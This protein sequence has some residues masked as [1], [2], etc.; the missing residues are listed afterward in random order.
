LRSKFRNFGTLHVCALC[1]HGCLEH[2]RVFRPE[3]RHPPSKG[4]IFAVKISK[5]RHTTYL[6]IVHAF[7]QCVL[8][9]EI[10]PSAWARGPKSEL[11][12]FG[13]L[14]VFYDVPIILMLNFSDSVPVSAE[15]SGPRSVTRCPTEIYVQSNYQNFGTCLQI[16][17]EYHIQRCGYDDAEYSGPKYG[18]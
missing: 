15:C 8:M 3:V 14:H 2:V 4:H 17:R 7:G 9:C 6:R 13:T 18:T 5:F 1:A 10:C 12:T 11:Q 16:V